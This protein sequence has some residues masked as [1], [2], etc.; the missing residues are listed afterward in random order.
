MNVQVRNRL[1]G[2]RAIIYANVP[3]IGSQFRQERSLSF[4]KQVYQRLPLLG[5]DFKE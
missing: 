1:P 3:S 2:G 4:S 5:S